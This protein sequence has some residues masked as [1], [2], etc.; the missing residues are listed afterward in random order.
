MDEENKDFKNTDEKKDRA[1]PDNGTAQPG[2]VIEK[3][4]KNV[5][6]KLHAAFKVLLLI[7]VGALFLAILQPQ[8]PDVIVA[9]DNGKG[10]SA[11]D[12]LNEKDG[13][14]V[15]ICL[16]Y[17]ERDSW[18][19]GECHRLS[20]KIQAEYDIY[21]E[22]S[23]DGS[24][25]AFSED[26][27]DLIIT[28]GYTGLSAENYLSCYNRLGADGYE[29]TH[30]E[31]ADGRTVA[32]NITAFRAEPARE[33]ADRFADYFLEGSRLFRSADSL[34]VSVTDT[35]GSFQPAVIPASGNSEFSVLTVTKP[36]GDTYSL[37]ALDSLIK[38][39]SPSLVVFLGG[40]DCGCSDRTELAAAWTE[41]SALLSLRGVP[42]CCVFTYEDAQSAV[43]RQILC[44]VIGSCPGFI[45]TG[46]SGSNADDGGERYETDGRSCL[47][48]EDSAGMPVYAL[49]ALEYSCFDS[50]QTVSETS[51]WMCEI[52]EILR[53]TCGRAVRSGIVLPGILEAA[54]AELPAFGG[55]VIQEG[56]TVNENT[57]QATLSYSS[58]IYD[59]LTYTNAGCCLFTAGNT[60]TGVLVR[61]SGV[62]SD[63][64]SV[65]YAL[66]FGLS[67]SLDFN[68]YGLGGRF[69]LNNSLRGALVLTYSRSDNAAYL[70]YRYASELGAV[71]R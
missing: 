8:L 50:A 43:S 63:D 13:S 57:A 71:K 16:V 56:V 6:Q 10:V 55:D 46:L 2:T 51:E 41:I 70:R 14:Q 68:S 7:A 31:N 69:E 52:S 21:T 39:S 23:S 65:P 26:L 53:R 19:A 1:A 60:N 33:A 12:L 32:V 58:L 49:Y 4:R 37:A 9:L 11:A 59:A 48:F 47:V 61:D 38:D 30:T 28:V 62:F 54:A 5:R 24:L 66:S 40:L 34:Y 15:M 17:S 25:S 3:G 20:E 18:A 22:V 64:A 45:D 35:D 44:E 67:G 27:Y 42:F 36:G 29:I